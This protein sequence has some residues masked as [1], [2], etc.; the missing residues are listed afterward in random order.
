MPA[1]VCL[2]LL[3]LP[4]DRSSSFARGAAEAPPHIRRAL[5]SPST[6]SSTEIGLA[7]EPETLDDRGDVA[8]GEDAGL[9]RAAIERAVSG[10]LAAGAVPLLLGGDHSVTYPALR[11][12][13]ARP[14]ASVLHIDAH[15]DLYDEFPASAPDGASSGLRPEDA[16]VRLHPVPGQQDR[17]S[18]ACPFARAM[19][20]GLTGRLVQVGIR[21]QTPHLKA[22]ATRFGVEVY[23]MDRWAEAPIETLPGPVYVSLDLDALDPAFAPGVA[24]PEPGGLSTRDVV[25]LLHRLR[26]PIA[27]GDVVELNPRHDV[28]DLTARVAAKLLKELAAVALRNG[29][30][31][32]T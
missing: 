13:A 5:W 30:V 27:G 18:H 4:W 29:P 12:F 2:A 20:E 26:A 16:S 25:A 28:R 11:A 32:T 7:I 8:L 31:A 24:H 1:A 23:G 22:Q 14:P 10:I 21:T 9:A 3:G 6:N 19:E 15:G 17:Y